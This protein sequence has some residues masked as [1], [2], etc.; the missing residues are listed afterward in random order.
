MLA[1]LAAGGVAGDAGD[2]E[3]LA[4]VRG[5][6]ARDAYADAD[7]PRPLSWWLAGRPPPPSDADRRELAAH[8]HPDGWLQ[9]LRQLYAGVDPEP[10]FSATAMSILSRYARVLDRTSWD[11]LAVAVAGDG[12]GVAGYA[13]AAW[14]DAHPAAGSGDDATPDDADGGDGGSTPAP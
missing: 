1:L 8:G 4:W 3:A 6:P 11:L 10:S 13:A 2:R 5:L 12:D 14:L 9:S 7:A